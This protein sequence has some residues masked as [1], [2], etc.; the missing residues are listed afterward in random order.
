MQIS[1]ARSGGMAFFPKSSIRGTVTLKDEGA[2]VSADASYRRTLAPEETEQLRSGADPAELDKAVAQIASNQK[3]GGADM[4][5]YE[6]TVKTKDGKSHYV[7]LNTALSSNE[8]QGVSPAT[9][10]VLRWIQDEAQKIS[11]HKMRGE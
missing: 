8:L 6:I 3:G 10:K 1:F 9:A 2:E 5:Q 4:Y 7:K 11:A